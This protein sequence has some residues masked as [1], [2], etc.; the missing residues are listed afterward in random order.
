M[1]G[2]HRY[3]YKQITHKCN[4]IKYL[5]CCL[6]NR[7]ESSHPLVPLWCSKYRKENSWSRWVSITGKDMTYT[8]RVFHYRC[9]N[10]ALICAHWGCSSWAEINLFSLSIANKNCTLKDYEPYALRNFPVKCRRCVLLTLE[11]IAEIVLQTYV[12]I[13]SLFNEWIMLKCRLL[14]PQFHIL[15]PTQHIQKHVLKCKIVKNIFWF[16]NKYLF[17]RG[18]NSHLNLN[19]FKLWPASPTQSNILGFKDLSRFFGV[20]SIEE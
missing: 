1:Y 18:N 8:N 17:L 19:W 5:K 14:N 15:L 10:W 4:K 12:V 11:T 6:Q 3:S 13:I 16:N 2:V 9:T 20:V 7:R